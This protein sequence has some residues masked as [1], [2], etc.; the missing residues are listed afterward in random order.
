MLICISFNYDLDV[1][2]KRVAAATCFLPNESLG[3]SLRPC[4][5]TKN[6][7]KRS[8]SF[9]SRWFHLKFKSID[10]ISLNQI[11]WFYFVKS[12]SS[13][14][15]TWRLNL[16]PWQPTASFTSKSHSSRLHVLLI[17]LLQNETCYYANEPEFRSENKFAYDTC[18]WLRSAMTDGRPIVIM[19]RTRQIYSDH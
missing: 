19:G 11:N 15:C 3:H 1:A 4:Y 16:L 10:S 7:T 13:R 6:L 17:R 5:T 18:R 9:S 8:I 14:R 12:I 2:C